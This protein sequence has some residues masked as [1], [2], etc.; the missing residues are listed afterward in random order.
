MNAR[1]S[2]QKQPYIQDVT[3]KFTTGAT[4]RLICVD[5]WVANVS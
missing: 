2:S 3:L 4:D 5:R 1:N